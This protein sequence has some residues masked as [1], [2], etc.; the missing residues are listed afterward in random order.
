MIQIS[1]AT[2]SG[3]R[4]SEHNII[5]H[6]ESGTL[7]ADV[8]FAGVSGPSSEIR[9][10][11]KGEEKF[12]TLPVPDD[13]WQGADRKVFFDPYVK[14]PVGPRLFIDSIVEDFPPSPDFYD[15]LKAQEVIDAALEADESGHWVS[16]G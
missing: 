5:F 14:Q 15:G 7:E 9:A 13:L 8:N 6:G 3:E 10:V 12:K 2:L 11:R 4:G 16:L 1:R